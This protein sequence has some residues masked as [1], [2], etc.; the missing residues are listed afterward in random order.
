MTNFTPA[1]TRLSRQHWCG[2]FALSILAGQDYDDAYK[3]IL[4]SL[5]AWRKKRGVARLPDRIQGMYPHEVMVASK[6]LG[7][8]L[9]WKRP[10]ANERNINPTLK[11]FLDHMLPRR[12]Y[13]INITRH[14]LTIDTHTWQWCDNHSRAWKPIDTC[15]WLRCRVEGFAE[16]QP[17]WIKL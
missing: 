17:K 4:R 5:R 16:Y 2:P 12:F 10:K 6:T 13:L 3:R 14:Y 9:T 1:P 8:N 15:K 11:Q 7:I